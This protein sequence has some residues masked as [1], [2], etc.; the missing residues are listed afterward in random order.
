MGIDVH[1]DHMVE[2]LCQEEEE[3][4]PKDPG[5]MVGG[6]WKVRGGGEG[7]EGELLLSMSCMMGRVLVSPVRVRGC[8]AA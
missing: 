8:V 6:D 1:L 5:S 7:G 2:L 4:D 3:R